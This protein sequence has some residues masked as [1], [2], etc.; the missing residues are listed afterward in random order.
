[1]PYDNNVVPGDF[2][3]NANRPKKASFEEAQDGFFLFSIP[4]RVPGLPFLVA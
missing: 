1:L 4:G 3:L 2:S